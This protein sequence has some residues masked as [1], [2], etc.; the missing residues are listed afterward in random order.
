MRDSPDRALVVSRADKAR[1]RDCPWRLERDA[2]GQ[3]TQL[4]A[5]RDE[6]AASHVAYAGGESREISRSPR[7]DTKCATGTYSQSTRNR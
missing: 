2:A 6:R 4:S 7:V 1:N 5:C 3:L